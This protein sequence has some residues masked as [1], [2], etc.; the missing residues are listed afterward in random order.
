[1][2]PQLVAIAVAGAALWAGYRWLARETGRVKEA[3]RAA[4]DELRRR[5]EEAAA[6]AGP[7]G[8]SSEADIFV[9]ANQAGGID[10]KALP[11]LELDPKTGEYRVKQ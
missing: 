1:M 7:T 3:M 5:A 8:G 9:V 4:E 10:M 11:K 2:P 6:M